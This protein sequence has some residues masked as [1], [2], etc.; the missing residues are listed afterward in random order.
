[1][2]QI[3]VGR[4]LVNLRRHGDNTANFNRGL[5]EFYCQP[6]VRLVRYATLSGF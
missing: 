1:M 4:R 5:L 2:P 6:V 3:G